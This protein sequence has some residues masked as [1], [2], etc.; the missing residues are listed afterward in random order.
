MK[1]IFRFSLLIPI[2]CCALGCSTET[3]TDINQYNVL[4]TS[5][6]ENSDAHSELYIFPNEI[7]KTKT[8]SFQYKHTEDLFNG[9]YLLY[10]V[11]KYEI[12]DFNNEI[13]RLGQIKSEF[14]KYNVTKTIIHDAS[15]NMYLTIFRNNSYE[16]AIYDDEQLKIS[17]VFNQLYRWEDIK[18]DRPI[19]AVNIPP[20]MDDGENEFNIYYY[21]QGDIGYYIED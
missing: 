5:L 6:K 3:N 7:D 9:S 12:S 1:K 16:Y 13:N 21:Y 14:T 8:I 10:L 20:E 11:Q 17:Y 15:Q 19:S 18:I 4:L 2:I